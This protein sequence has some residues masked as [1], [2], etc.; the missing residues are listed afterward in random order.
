MALESP[1]SR[2]MIP[3]SSPPPQKAPLDR[4]ELQKTRL[5]RVDVDAA[6]MLF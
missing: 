2:I 3:H 5:I 1:V 6:E 4:A